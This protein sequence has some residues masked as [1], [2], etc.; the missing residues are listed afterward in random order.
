MTTSR[1]SRPH[2][3]PNPTLIGSILV[4]FTLICVALAYNANRGLPFVPTYDVFVEVPDAAR[5]IEAGSEVR[6]GGSRV[7]VVDSIAAVRGPAQRAPYARVGLKL[8][9]SH[10]ELPVDTRVTVRP[11]SLL[12]AKYVALTPGRS[13]RTLAEGDTLPLRQ[14][15]PVVEVSDTFEIFGKRSAHAMQQTVIELGGG[16]A[17]RGGQLNALF[18]ETRQL[19]PPLQSVLETLSAPATDTAGFVT[20]LASFSAALAPVADDLAALIDAA[21]GTVA[22]L[23]RAGDH[24][25]GVVDGAARSE[26]IAID[27]SRRLEP[28]L[29]DAAAIARGLRPAGQILPR[30]AGTIATALGRATPGLGRV[31]ELEPGLRRVLRGL[32]RVVAEPTTVPALRRVVTASGALNEVLA[33]LLPAQRNCNLLGVWARNTGSLVARGDA[34][35][36]WMSFLL[37]FGNPD[38]VLQH[39]TPRANAHIN[40]YPRT[41]DRECESGNEP[42][43]P[44]TLI[45]SPPGI[46]RGT[47]ETLPPAG[48]TERARRAGLL[49]VSP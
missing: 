4:M 37:M 25:P 2:A 40:P 20:A 12:G 46:Q 21:G 1:D 9:E 47:D 33:G 38:E 23:D 7:G 32:D 24:L 13:R 42:Y 5:L 15:A 17:G 35:G 28:V 34:H 45:G 36:N 11:R 18:G 29:R 41:D 43:A 3:P 8:D 19:L 27:A 26:R 14:A 48:V 31:P 39:P 49:E 6:I 10:A 30:A 44:G 16:L 22:A